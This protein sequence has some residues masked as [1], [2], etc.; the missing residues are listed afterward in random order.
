MAPSF[1]IKVNTNKQFLQLSAEGHGPVK[2]D[3][4][5]LG[6]GESLF[7]F[8]LNYDA[9]FILWS[10]YQNKLSDIERA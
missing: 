6:I 7:K 4:L 1:L 9:T 3:H 5:W 2:G 8:F 10:S